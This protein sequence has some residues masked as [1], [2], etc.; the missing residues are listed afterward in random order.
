MIEILIVGHLDDKCPKT[1]DHHHN[2]CCCNCMFCGSLNHHWPSEDEE[3]AY[4]LESAENLIFRDLSKKFDSDSAIFE[5]MEKKGFLVCVNLCLYR[6]NG[7]G[8]LH[9]IQI[10]SPDDLKGG[11]DED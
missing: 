6:A 2:D 1:N 4:L 5:L 3:K 7:S 10:P 9:T 8:P 11:D